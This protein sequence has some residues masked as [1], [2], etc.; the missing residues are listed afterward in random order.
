MKT[1]NQYKKLQ[2]LDGEDFIKELFK[3]AT[4]GDIEFQVS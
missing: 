1:D 3:V 4:K 2:D